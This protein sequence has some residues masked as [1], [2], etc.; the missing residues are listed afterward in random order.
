MN[1]KTGIK[2]KQLMTLL[3]PILTRALDP[4]DKLHQNSEQNLDNAFKQMCYYQ[5]Y[6]E[7]QDRINFMHREYKK[8]KTIYL[9]YSEP[10]LV[11][12]AFEKGLIEKQTQ[13]SV[14]SHFLSSPSTFCFRKN[15]ILNH[16]IHKQSQKNN[17]KE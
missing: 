13:K 7:K 5:S 14:L 3:E 4:A 6:A 9:C 8:W 17:T 16:L 10:K 12:C 1:T 11:L 2:F 15:G